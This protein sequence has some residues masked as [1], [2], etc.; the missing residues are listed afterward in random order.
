MPFKRVVILILVLLPSLAR[1]EDIAALFNLEGV[2]VVSVSKKQENSFDAASAIYVI[3]QD[4]IERSGATSIPEALR[5][6]PGLEV[7]KTDSNKWAISS[8]GFN[9]VFANKILVLID[10]RSVYTPLFSGTAWDVQDTILED[11]SRIEVIRGPGATLWGSNAV[12][13]VINIITKDASLTQGNHV[14]LTAGNE[15]QSKSSYRYG[16]KIGDKT[17][18]RIYGKHRKYDNSKLLNGE[19]ANDAWEFAS[20]GFRADIRQ[21]AS[22]RFTLQGD[23]Y[24]STNDAPGIGIPSSL[25][26]I[27]DN[28]DI[29]GGNIMFKWD[30]AI[31]SHSTFNLQSYLDYDSRSF[32]SLDQERYTFDI[33]LQHS[34]DFSDRNELVWGGGYRIFKDELN[35]NA[36][37]GVNIIDYTPDESYNNLYNAFIQHKY[38]IVPKKLV[39]TT[40]TKFEHNYYTGLETQPSVRLAWYPNHQ[41]T[42]WSSVTRS[43]RIPSRGERTINLI[44]AGTNPFFLRQTG[45]P[46]FDSEELIAYELG[47]RVKPRSNLKFDIATFYNDYDSLRSFELV[48]PLDIIVDNNVSANAFGGE[49]TAEWNVKP[50]WQLIASYGYLN[51]Q[52]HTNEGST[53]IF[54]EAD[55]ERSPENQFKLRSHVNVTPDIEWDTIAY[56]V[57]ELNNFGVNDYVR[58][59]LRLGWTPKENVRLSLVGQNLLDDKHQEFS[60]ASLSQPTQVERSF[61]GNLTVNF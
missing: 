34:Y 46:N 32:F 45:N 1:S 23:L 13:G 5:L 50:N 25:S 49:I 44:A 14:S 31:S 12:N 41:S 47:Y 60:G 28:E 26:Q 22:N 2:K 27:S 38:S 53:D 39:L 4:D 54:T 18:Y 10:G 33:E 48:S 15:I 61:Y 8:R 58:L 17:Y 9:R 30:H 42:V 24:N 21:D 55:E 37:D 20:A 56:Y 43:V 6:A 35:S 52:L 16:G 19:D 51:L 40:G 57:D 7:A 11:I 59:D 29:K 36:I 3:T